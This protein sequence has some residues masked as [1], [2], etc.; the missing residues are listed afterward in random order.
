MNYLLDSDI[1]IDFF[2]GKEHAHAVFQLMGR[3][4]K[5]MSVVVYGELL[6]GA[7]KSKE[8][9]EGCLEVLEFIKQNKV[10]VLPVTRK[11]AEEYVKIRVDLE[12]RGQKLPG[13]DLLIAATAL[14]QDLILVTGNKSRFQRI[15]RL[16]IL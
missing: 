8:P 15:K 9:K 14:S 7:K 6:V 13:L 10:T 1:T 12:K 4:R 11:M 16:K 5:F 2:K 3:A